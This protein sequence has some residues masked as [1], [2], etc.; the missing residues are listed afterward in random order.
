[1]NIIC[2]K[3]LMCLGWPREPSNAKWDM[4]VNKPIKI[5]IQYNHA[6]L[7]AQNNNYLTK[8]DIAIPFLG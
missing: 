6:Y 1:M 2:V 7:V 8:K 5:E 3:K 4:T